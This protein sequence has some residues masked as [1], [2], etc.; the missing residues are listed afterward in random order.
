M[1]RGGW[2]LEQDTM[3]GSIKRVEDDFHTEER[4]YVGLIIELE[5][6]P[7][8]KPAAHWVDARGAT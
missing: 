3:S 5:S 6:V 1:P 2:V 8:T 4:R 7:I